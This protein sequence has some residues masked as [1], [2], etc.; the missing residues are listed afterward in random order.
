MALGRAIRRFEASTIVRQ[1]EVCA[2][3][4]A[5]AFLGGTAAFATG[6]GIGREVEFGGELGFH[7]FHVGVDR[8]VLL[9]ES[10]E[11]SRVV[12]ALVLSYAEGMKG[13]DLG[14]LSQVQNVAANKL[15]VVKRPK[16][17]RA[18]STTLIGY[19]ASVP[20]NWFVN[21][22][23]KLVASEMPVLDRSDRIMAD[24]R[25]ISSIKAL[26]QGIVSG[27]FRDEKMESAFA[28]LSDFDAIDL[29]VGEPLGLEHRRPI[30]DV[31]LVQL[32]RGAGMYFDSRFAQK[33]L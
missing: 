22:C 11:A 31:K 28:T 23:R 29:A 17:F 33:I 14:W 5:L 26:R 6:S 30:L 8:V 16:D 12:G 19:K 25:T 27:K 4:C 1:R 15:F 20:A 21:V 7:G 24:V 2:S 32:D 13:V 18:I 3:A 9:N 10:L